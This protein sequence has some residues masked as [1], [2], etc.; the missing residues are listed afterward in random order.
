[1]KG[2]RTI[3]IFI[4]PPGSGKGTLAQRCVD[5]FGWAKLSTGDLCRLHISQQ[6]DIGK[7]IDF[8]I[9]A[10]KLIPDDLITAMVADWLN[11]RV[12]T[13]TGIILD[14]YPR[15]HQQVHMLFDLIDTQFVG[16]R[17]K[18]VAFDISD[19]AVI[20]RLSSRRICENKECQEVYSVLSGSSLAPERDMV[21]DSCGS[22]LIQRNDDRVN[23]IRDRLAIYHQHDPSSL[24]IDKGHVVERI[25]S[26]RLLCEVFDNFKQLEKLDFAL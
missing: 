14:G 10:G 21:C 18:V 16:L 2:I 20:K 6:T 23:V 26:D 12:S 15:T 13:S 25:D 8:L 7:Q 9:K 1:M 5:E 11:S 19:D 24:F 4:G 3:Y 17:I 22:A